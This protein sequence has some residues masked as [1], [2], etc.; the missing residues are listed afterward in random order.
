MPERDNSG[1]C[2]LWTFESAAL[3]RAGWSCCRSAGH[4][5]KAGSASK[6]ARV[7]QLTGLSDALYAEAYVT[8]HQ[9]DI[10]LDVSVINRTGDTMQARVASCHPALSA[11]TAPLPLTASAAAVTLPG[12]PA[13]RP[14]SNP[15]SLPSHLCPAAQ[16]LPQG[17][18]PRDSSAHFPQPPHHRACSPTSVLSQPQQQLP[19]KGRIGEPQVNATLM[20]S[21]S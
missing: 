18:W 20:S 4:A 11:A 3:P 8:V 2:M 13:G 15:A 14:E 19:D 12:T 21:Y 1:T 9:Y 16:H 6:L 17:V 7:V 10:S 5:G